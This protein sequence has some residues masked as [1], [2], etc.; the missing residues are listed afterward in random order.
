[1]K[2]FFAK[3]SCYFLSCW[4]PTL[5]LAGELLIER[6]ASCTMQKCSVFCGKRTFSGT[7]FLQTQSS[8]SVIYWSICSIHEKVILAS[9]FRYDQIW[10]VYKNK[11]CVWL[12]DET[13]FRLIINT[14]SANGYGRKH[15]IELSIFHIQAISQ[16]DPV[17]YRFV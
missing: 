13:L 4:S 16:S 17:G 8:K 6:L 15:A 10:S 14:L 3:E 11:N 7:Q 1:M 12:T 5:A 2:I 9:N